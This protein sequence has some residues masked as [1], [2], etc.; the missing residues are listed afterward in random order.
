MASP[1]MS[2][3]AGRDSPNP[4]F[5]EPFQFDEHKF[6]TYASN[7]EKQELYVFNWLSNLE[8]ELKK[9]DK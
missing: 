1:P 9:T 7:P 5:N 2:S 4:S 6:S 8:R 3:T